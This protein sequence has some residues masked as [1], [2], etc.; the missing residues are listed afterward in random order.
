MDSGIIYMLDANGNQVPVPDTNAPNLFLSVFDVSQLPKITQLGA[1]S[2]RSSARLES[3]STASLAEAG[4][5]GLVGRERVANL[6]GLG[7][8]RYLAIGRSCHRRCLTDRRPALLLGRKWRTL[9][10][11]RRG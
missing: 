1:T 6:V 11:L 9:A 2:G 10:C 8:G 7:R 4:N 3:E 5:P